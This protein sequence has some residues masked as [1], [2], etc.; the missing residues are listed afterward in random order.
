MRVHMGD[1]LMIRTNLGEVR[2]HAVIKRRLLDRF[3]EGLE[4][5][6]QWL[7]LLSCDTTI[8][9][10]ASICCIEGNGEGIF[11]QVRDL[12]LGPIEFRH[13]MDLQ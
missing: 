4:R 13:A 10:L 1:T 11:A 9:V 7:L 2:V 6:L 5:T 8:V 12:V 3:S